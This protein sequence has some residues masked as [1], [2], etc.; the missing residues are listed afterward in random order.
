MRL[1]LLLGLIALSSCARAPER[2]V[3][4]EGEAGAPPGQVHVEAAGQTVTLT[5]PLDATT[6]Q[7]TRLTPEAVT[8]AFLHQEFGAVLEALPRPLHTYLVLFASATAHLD[9]GGK[10]VLNQAL[11][12]IQAHPDSAITIRGHTDAQGNAAQNELLAWRRARCVLAYLKRHGMTHT[13]VLVEGVG[14]REATGA[15]DEDRRVEVW[16]R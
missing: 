10:A 6:L 2:V 13:P 3:L 5:K 7:G 12:A 1:W 11:G 8:A 14:A 15:P 16:V 9:P 4:L